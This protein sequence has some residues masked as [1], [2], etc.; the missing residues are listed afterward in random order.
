MGTKIPISEARKRLSELL[1]TLQKDPE[2]IYEITV[3]DIV[4]GELSAPKDR[5]LRR[6]AAEAL[7]RAA[8]ELSRHHV[9]GA[10]R[11]S[12]AKDHDHYLYGRKRK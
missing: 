5:R 9:G 11:Q 7:L 2:A 3:N 1:K 8:E 12:V 6:G 4:F 10:K